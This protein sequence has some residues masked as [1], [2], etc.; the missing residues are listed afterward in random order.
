MSSKHLSSQGQLLWNQLIVQLTWLRSFYCVEL[1]SRKVE[2]SIT[3]DSRECFHDCMICKWLPVITHL[4]PDVDGISE[5]LTV[6][7]CYIETV[8]NYVVIFA[9][10]TADCLRE[11]R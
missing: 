1:T 11:E 5:K 8:Y 3:K 2:S 6:C 9:G 4:K 7:K 10:I